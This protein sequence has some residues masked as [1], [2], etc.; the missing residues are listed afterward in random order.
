MKSPMGI[1][2]SL[3]GRGISYVKAQPWL[4]RARRHLAHGALEKARTC[5]I[6]AS[7]ACSELGAA[8]TLLAR[9]LMPGGDYRE[10]LSYLHDRLRPAT[11]VEIG[12]RTAGS[13]ALAGACTAAIGIDPMFRIERP[14]R[15]RARL[16]PLTSDEFFDHYDLLEELHAPRLAMAFVDGL[17]HFE[18]V[19]RDFINLERYADRETLMLF[20]DCLPVSRIAATRPP[21]TTMRCGDVWKIIP[22]LRKYRPDLTVRILPTIPSGLGIVI[23]GDRNSSVL[24]QR[25]EQIV[26]EH[27]DM[28]LDYEYLTPELLE[29]M[30]GILPNDPQHIDEA[31]LRPQQGGPR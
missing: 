13:L 12:V 21:R 11:Y 8:Q 24:G 25:L 10:V 27:R 14:I 7:G 22:C 1:G 6:K 17:H 26:A 5:C 28:E 29:Q 23:G 30:P 15:A 4:F 16:Y 9:I 18:Q 31:I 3:V 2:V 19:L 20:H